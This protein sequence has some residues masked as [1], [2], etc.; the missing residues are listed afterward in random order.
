VGAQYLI[1]IRLT[2][3]LVLLWWGRTRWILQES[4]QT[5]ASLQ[6]TITPG[7]AFSLYTQQLVAGSSLSFDF[8]L[9]NNFVSG[10][11]DQFAFQIYDAGLSTLLF[12]RTFDI[13]GAETVP[14]PATVVLMGMGLFGASAYLR[15]RRVR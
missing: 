11:F 15:R 2:R 5:L 9:T 12:E 1:R 3:R 7:D 10:S 13:T 14:E 6:L 8:T 4:G